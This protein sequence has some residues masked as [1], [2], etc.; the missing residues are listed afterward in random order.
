MKHYLKK[1]AISG[2]ISA[3]LFA[4]LFYFVYAV[5]NEK[6][7][8]TAAESEKTYAGETVSEVNT[9]V[10]QTIENEIVKKGSRVAQAPVIQRISATQPKVFI[11][12]APT[13]PLD[14]PSIPS[15]PPASTP[16]TIPALP[17]ITIPTIP[18]PAPAPRTTTTTTPTQPKPAPA[19]APRTTVS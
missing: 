16:I 12:S 11:G 6:Y 1:L 13:T 17:A 9:I 14:I 3:T 18:S 19:P 7:A 8:P 5:E 15:A 2:A 10:V 4:V